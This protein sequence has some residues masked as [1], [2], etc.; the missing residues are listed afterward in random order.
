MKK[1]IVFLVLL[2][3]MTLSVYFNPSKFFKQV[4]ASKGKQLEFHWKYCGDEDSI[5]KILEGDVQ[6]QPIVAYRK[7]VMNLCGV[8]EVVEKIFPSDLIAVKFI[9]INTAVKRVNVPIYREKKSGCQFIEDLKYRD[10]LCCVWNAVGLNYTC[11]PIKPGRY[12]ITNSSTTFDL[13]VIPEILREMVEKYG[14]GNYMGEIKGYRG[15]RF[16]GCARVEGHGTFKNKYIS[17]TVN[18][19]TT[20]SVNDVS[21]F[22]TIKTSDSTNSHVELHFL[23]IV[24]Q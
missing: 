21:Q 23:R 10:V 7:T 19:S 15:D 11:E 17:S 4:K 24:F 1:N 6:P 2:S 13:D 22:T 3:S 9:R 5:V 18:Y 14:S 12:T 20:K 8:V 16:L